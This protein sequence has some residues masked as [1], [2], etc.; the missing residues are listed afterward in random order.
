[1]QTA[2]LQQHLEMG[3]T[4]YSANR[5]IAVTGAALAI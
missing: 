5:E 2:H 4:E 3:R 1:V